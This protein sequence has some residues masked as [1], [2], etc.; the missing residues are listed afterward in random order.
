MA[1]RNYEYDENYGFRKE[2]HPFVRA[3]VIALWWLLGSILLA[4]VYHL[5]FSLVWNTEKDRSLFHENRMYEKT[6]PE[7]RARERMLREVVKD[8]ERRD[9]DIYLA[10]FN[11]S[12]PSMSDITY[13]SIIP[14]DDELR[15]DD[16]F[17]H[18][19]NSVGKIEKSVDA[20]EA[21]FRRVFEI[22]G[23]DYYTLP[24]MTLPLEGFNAARTGASVGRRISPFFKVAMAHDG[25]D[26]IAP[27][28]TP[29]VAGGPG[30]VVRT[31]H[32]SGSEGNV[33]VIDHGNGYTTKYAHLSEIR[34]SSGRK[35]RSGERIGT[36]GTSGKSFAPHL[37]YSLMHG[38][39]VCDPVNYFFCSITPQEYATMLIL[40]GSTGQSMD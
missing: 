15:E 2:R 30:V 37:H 3:L 35:V 28:G 10:V 39:E 21:D 36:V 11:T 8:L 32:A 25:I 24:P 31:E 27:V 29:V 19:A 4:C 5:V 20:V 7:L 34:V 6:Y 12:A 1:A 22:C 9:D 26:L 17:R 23:H 38:S 33:V 13:G 18:I 14:D 40:S 16:I